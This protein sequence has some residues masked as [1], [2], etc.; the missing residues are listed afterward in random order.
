MSMQSMQSILW[1]G[2]TD[3]SFLRNLL[4]NPREVLQQFGLTSIEV[5]A[6]ADSSPRSLVDLAATVEAWRS[7]DPLTARSRELALAG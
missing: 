1:Q 4:E 3:Q 5:E 6:L 7:G 2:A